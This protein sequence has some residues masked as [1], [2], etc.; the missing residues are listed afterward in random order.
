M[1]QMNDKSSWVLSPSVWA[2]GGSVDTNLSFLSLSERY[3][4]DVA[5]RRMPTRWVIEA[6][7]VVKHVG[8]RLP[9]LRYTFLAMRSVFIE[10]KKLPIA[11]LSQTS[12]AL[13]ML[14]VMLCSRSNCWKCALVY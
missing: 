2:A 8:A 12:P 4:T 11:E 7:Y 3:G 10:M 9:L 5:Q 6:P 14:Q 13:L 1:G